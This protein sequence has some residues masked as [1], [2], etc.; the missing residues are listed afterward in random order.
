MSLIDRS[1]GMTATTTIPRT[2]G[3]GTN[4]WLRVFANSAR[5]QKT[6]ESDLVFGFL[7]E[8]GMDR[9]GRAKTDAPAALTLRASLRAASTN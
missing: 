2:S 6:K 4:S 3:C 5:R 1:T 9:S 7:M 8:P